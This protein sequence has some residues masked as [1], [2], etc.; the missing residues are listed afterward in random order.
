MKKLLLLAAFISSA[1][2]A[3]AQTAK[4]VF[5][6]KE[7]VWY[8]LD[9]SKTH[10]VGQFDQGFGIVPATGMD[11]RNKWAGAWN[12]LIV[13]EQNNFD[14]RKAFRA[15]NVYFDLGPIAEQNKKIDSDRCMSFNPAKISKEEI[16]EMIKQYVPG[17]KT[18]GIGLVFIVENFNKN[19]LI[20]EMY[21]TY[22]D[23]ATK[24]VLMIEKESARPIGQG[25]RNYWAG[26]VKSVLRNI[27]GT[28]YKVWKK[29]Y[30]K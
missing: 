3:S 6:A 11:M 5:T 28:D 12:E 21:V 10:F 18:T 22:F 2:G 19:D 15:D 4:D 14:L 26:S 24:K 17:E 16:A 9:F 7:I 20:G 25:L 8:G 27:E 29:E 30:S 23:I 1:F 13:K